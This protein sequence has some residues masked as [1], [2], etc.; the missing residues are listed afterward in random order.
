[1]AVSQAPEEWTERA[2][3]LAAAVGSEDIIDLQKFLRC[4]N[5]GRFA[6]HL[7]TN[8][9]DSQPQRGIGDVFAVP[10]QQVLHSAQG[11]HRNVKGI[12]GSLGR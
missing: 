10:C 2:D 4:A 12:D 11:R 5:D 1:M 6:A 9:I 7:A 8:G 3:L